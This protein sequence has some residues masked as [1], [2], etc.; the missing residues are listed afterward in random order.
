[1]RLPCEAYAIDKVELRN[2]ASKTLLS[3]LNRNMVPAKNVITA[4]NHVLK[5]GRHNALLGKNMIC[6]KSTN[7][8]L[9]GEAVSDQDGVI[10]KGRRKVI[11]SS[12][13]DEK[14]RDYTQHS[15]TGYFSLA[16]N[17]T[18][19]TASCW[20]LPAT[21]DQKET[22]KQHEEGEVLT[23]GKNW[24]RSVRT[25]GH[26]LSSHC[27]LLLQF[28]RDWLPV[29]QNDQLSHYQTEGTICEIWDTR[30]DDNWL[31]H[32]VSLTLFQ[33]FQ[34]KDGTIHQATSSSP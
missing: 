24:C 27:W 26:K 34:T 18:G 1:M 6:Y 20:T 7:H 2:Q 31:W 15:Y 9:K 16:R 22:P 12:L 19:A 3:N 33:E 30:T 11:P 4:A 14:K 29:Y 5:N 23:G 17:V 32:T 21:S 10:L 25:K 28:N 13:R 8:I